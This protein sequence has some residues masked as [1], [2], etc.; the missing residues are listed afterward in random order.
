M[1]PRR[2]RISIRQLMIGVAVIGIIT[3]AGVTARNV[4]Y[5]HEHGYLL[6][7]QYL[8]D[9]R[10]IQTSGHNAPFWPRYWRRL[11]ARPWPGSYECPCEEWSGRTSLAVTHPGRFVDDRT[12]SS[13]N[14]Y[15]IFELNMQQHEAGIIKLRQIAKDPE[16][17]AYFD[18]SFKYLPRP[19]ASLDED[20]A[21]RK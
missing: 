21:N 13:L 18:R 10:H 7:T 15:T 12:I 17:K 16:T 2:V 19:I 11:L 20:L 9:G 14:K 4:Y 6:H 5:D 8:K 1:K 3:W